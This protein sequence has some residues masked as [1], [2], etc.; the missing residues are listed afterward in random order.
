M[1]SLHGETCPAAALHRM[2]GSW[3]VV[4]QPCIIFKE[5]ATCLPHAAERAAAHAA[6]PVD[7]HQFVRSLALLYR[8]D[9]HIG[10]NDGCNAQLLRTWPMGA[11]EGRTEPTHGFG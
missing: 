5:R 3:P 1:R 9:G 6:A 8:N 7:V 10:A 2:D 4:V 11:A